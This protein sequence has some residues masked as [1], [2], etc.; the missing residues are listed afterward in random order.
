MFQGFQTCQLRVY[1]YQQQP[2]EDIVT[3]EYGR[4]SYGRKNYYRLHSFQ[5]DKLESTQILRTRNARSF[6]PLAKELAFSKFIKVV[7]MK[8]KQNFMKLSSKIADKYNRKKSPSRFIV[9][10]L[11]GNDKKCLAEKFKPSEILEQLFHMGIQKHNDVIY[12]MTN[13]RQNN[14]TKQLEKEFDSFY[15]FQSKDVKYFGLNLFTEMESYLTYAVELQLQFIADAVIRT[16]KGHQMTAS[17]NL[18]GYLSSS[19]C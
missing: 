15:L 13:M 11:R 17:K 19:K 4:I 1:S 10:H 3:V 6:Q 18:I 16:Y 9:V 2:L 7:A 8:I 12:V 14:F 5:P